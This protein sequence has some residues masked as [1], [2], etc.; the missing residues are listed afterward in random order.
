MKRL[1]KW[2]YE[3]V[4]E[5]PEGYLLGEVVTSGLLALIAFNII[6]GMFETVESL[7]ETYT[8]FFYWVEFVSVVIFTIEYV[9]RAWACTQDPRYGSTVWGRIRFLLTPMSLVDL[10][11]IAPFYLSAI[12]PVD[13]RFIR[14]LRLF[15]LLRL[16]RA[17][18]LT[19]S[20]DDLLHVIKSKRKE[21]GISTA[22]LVLVVVVSANLMYL[23][24]HLEPGTTFT[25]VPAA[26]WWGMMTITTIGYGDMYPTTPLGQVIASGVGFFGICVFALPVGILGAG[27]TNYMEE[28]RSGE[29]GP[30]GGDGG[31]CEVCPHCARVIPK[32]NT[33]NEPA[34]GSTA[35]DGQA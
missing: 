10:L 27:F 12:F 32:A 16:F 2:M 23:V 18:N 33:A 9:L 17:S 8:G 6:V 22:M 13:L 29:A 7:R 5:P 20:F 35:P 30:G 15:R 26:L 1:R 3:T 11:A 28:K 4:M 25:S 31:S 21:L 24:E 14:I 19:G 34:S